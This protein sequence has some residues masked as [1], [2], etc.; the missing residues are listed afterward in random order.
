MFLGLTDPHTTVLVRV[1]LCRKMKQVNHSLPYKLK[2]SISI[3][4]NY[5]IHVHSLYRIGL[6]FQ[7]WG[8]PGGAKIFKEGATTF[9]N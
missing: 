8:D 9:S 2:I 3:H 5:N 4:N 1:I 6:N 7:G